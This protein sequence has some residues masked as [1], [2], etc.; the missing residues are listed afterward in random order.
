[1]INFDTTLKS[2]RVLK[3]A[4]HCFKQYGFKRTSMDDIAKSAEMSRPALYLLFKN[5]TDIFRSIAA[6]FHE[7]TLTNAQT[8]LD[9]DVDIQTKLLQAITIRKLPLYALAHDSV[10]GPELFDVTMS[11]A[12]DINTQ[13]NTRFFASLEQAI[14]SAMDSGDIAPD[15]ITGTITATELSQILCAGAYGLKDMATNSDQYEALLT[16]MVHTIF[17]GL[18]TK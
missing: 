6:R 13:A 15:T 10:H 1:M 12:A 3:A 11:T 16:K 7:I 18:H 8:A 4:L 2:D 17:A 5:K 14:Q 9:S